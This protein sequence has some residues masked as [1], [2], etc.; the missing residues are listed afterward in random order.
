MFVKF[1]Q[2]CIENFLF[3]RVFRGTGR[4]KNLCYR[5]LSDLLSFAAM[6][7]DL[8]SF[9]AMASVM[10]REGTRCLELFELTV[11]V[12]PGFVAMGRRV[13]LN[14]RCR[15]SRD[16][17]RDTRHVGCVFTRHAIPPSPRLNLFGRIYIAQ[18]AFCLSSYRKASLGGFPHLLH[19]SLLILSRLV[20]V[21]LRLHSLL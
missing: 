3:S 19:R 13:L 15:W 4:G 21:L 12:F 18:C 17:R 14:A 11:G 9:A 8:L 1:I 10:R 7:N 20:P 16:T 6:A 2:Q 5:S